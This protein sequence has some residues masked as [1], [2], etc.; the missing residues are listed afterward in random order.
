MWSE[1]SEF[2]KLPTTCINFVIV[3]YFYVLL[4]MLLFCVAAL[5]SRCSID[6]RC[7]PR[8]FEDYLHKDAWGKRDNT[9][10]LVATVSVINPHIYIYQ[11]N[12]LYD[13]L[14]CLIKLEVIREVL[15]GSLYFFFGL[16]QQ[17]TLY[18]TDVKTIM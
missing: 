9:Y 8:Y 7:R 1:S 12:K 11:F 4:S 5:V 18:S 6:I 17:P 14:S 3:S 15:L 16:C 13:K 2:W 10:N